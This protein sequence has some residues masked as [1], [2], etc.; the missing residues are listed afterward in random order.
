M[1]Q[2]LFNELKGNHIETLKIFERLNSTYPPMKMLMFDWLEQGLKSV[3]DRESI[4][5]LMNSE[6]T[7]LVILILSNLRLT[8]TKIFLQS[9]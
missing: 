7:Y 1:L 8:R 9:Y 4:I 3:R 2:L 6:Y 5:S